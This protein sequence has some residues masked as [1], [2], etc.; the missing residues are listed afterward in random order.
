MMR[1][2]GLAV[3][4]SFFVFPLGCGPHKDN[5]DNGAGPNKVT[6][7]AEPVKVG[8]VTDAGGIDDKSFNASAW[9]GLQKAQ[10]EL[11]IEPKYLESREQADYKS[12]LSS[13]AEQKSGLVF[14]VG[15]LMED[16]LK[17]IAPSYP[18]TKFAI[19]DGSAP[20]DPNC[21]SIKFK[22]EEGCFLAGYLAGKM[23]K[24]GA[25]GFVGGMEGTLIKK[26]ECGYIA[27]ARTA[28]PDIRVAIKYVGSWK[29]VAKGKEMALVEFNRDGADIVFQA[30]GKSGLGVLD[31]ANEKGAGFYGIGVD[32]DQDDVHPGRVLCSMMKGVDTAVFDTVKQFNEGKWLAGEHVFGIKDGGVH[33]S[34]MKNTKKDVPAEV[35]AKI[36]QIS[37]TIGDGKFKVPST[38]DELQNF[39]PP[40]I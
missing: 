38:A 19:I 27:G 13:L 10:K 36:E 5:A 40:K 23:T 14:A 6:G 4:F 15:Y 35:L 20:N 1:R 22:E 28:R 24:T 7:T 39:Q 12:N 25:I 37:K 17:E 16:A 2:I 31:A 34:P 33:L 21:A 9:S 11:G 30:A 18:N 29:D 26:F 32:A 3:W 8:Q